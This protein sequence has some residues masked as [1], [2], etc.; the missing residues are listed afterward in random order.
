MGLSTFQ[1][2]YVKAHSRTITFRD[3]LKNKYQNSFIHDY[4]V[5]TSIHVLKKLKEANGNSL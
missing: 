4:P 3:F 2:E 1:S 5:L